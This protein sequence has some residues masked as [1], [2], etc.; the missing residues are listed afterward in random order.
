M[1]R[2]VRPPS[3]ISSSTGSTVVPAASSTT[4]RSSLASLLSSEDLP[5]L[6]RPTI[7]TRRGPPTS[8]YASGGGSGSA[9]RIASSMSPEP[10]P[11]SAETG[12]GSPSPRFHSAAASASVRWSSTL[13]AASTTGL[14]DFRRTL[15]I[16]TRRGPPT[17][18]YASGGGSG[19]APRIASSMSP[20]PRPCSAE[21]GYGSPSPRFHSA[22]ASASV[23][24]SSTLLA[25]STTG[26]PDFRRT[27]TTAS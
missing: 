6:G 13:L 19:S 12:Y 17:S 27:L 20:E 3:W 18:P 4:A 21:T 24:W 1:N 16:A 22:A 8:P 23:R 14:P 7:A 9:P 2:Q 26:L 10:R 15:T 11:C 25:A 5:T